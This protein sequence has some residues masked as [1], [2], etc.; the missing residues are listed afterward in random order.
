MHCIEHGTL[1]ASRERDYAE[2]KESS[3][4]LNEGDPL[5]LRT[6][7]SPAVYLSFGQRFVVVRDETIEDGP[8]RIH[9]REYWYRFELDDDVELLAFHWTPET[10]NSQEKRYPH[11]HVG[12]ALLVE[13]TPIL[14]GVLHKR[15]IP[16]GRVSIESI[17][18]FAI[19]ELGV[20]PLIPNWSDVLEQG[21]R[22]FDRYR[23]K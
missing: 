22:Q 18:R 2:D 12:A 23:R 7:S 4:L 16:T 20:L 13:T 6:A 9:T 5:R 1:V 19:E 14:P 11:L 15:H 8:F 21:Q 3:I 17:I 10:Q